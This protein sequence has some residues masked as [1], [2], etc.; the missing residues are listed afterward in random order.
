MDELRFGPA[1]WHA[2]HV[3]ETGDDTEFI[4]LVAAGAA[5]VA[6]GTALAATSLLIG[7]VIPLGAVT[8]VAFALVR[9]VQRQ[10]GQHVG[11]KPRRLDA[12]LKAAIADLRCAAR[13]MV[14]SGIKSFVRRNPWPP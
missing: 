1:V 7:L 14:V 2:V 13:K 11:C 8:L 4:S 5:L 6:T 12:F 10:K 3:G 9:M